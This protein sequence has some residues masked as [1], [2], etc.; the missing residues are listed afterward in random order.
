MVVSQEDEALFMQDLT[1]RPKLKI[2]MYFLLFFFVYTMMYVRT[3]ALLQQ[4]RNNLHPL[5]ADKM[6]INRSRLMV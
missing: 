6:A 5:K 3:Y 2:K 1:L 4:L